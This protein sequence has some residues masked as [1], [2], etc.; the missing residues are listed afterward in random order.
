M[1]CAVW[2]E[3]V[4]TSQSFWPRPIPHIKAN[5]Q[6]DEQAGYTTPRFGSHQDQLEYQ[7]GSETYPPTRNKVK[8]NNLTS[9][10]YYNIIA[11]LQLLIFTLER[12]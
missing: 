5:S 11:P 6:R 12:S 4:I 10:Y 7:H 3:P 1:L 8:I 9:Y 2:V